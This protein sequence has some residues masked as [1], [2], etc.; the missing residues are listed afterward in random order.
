M[1]FLISAGA[2]LAAAMA[3][4]AVGQTSGA[5]SAPTTTLVKFEIVN[6]TIPSPLTGK[7]GNPKGGERVVVG[8]TDGN[9]LACHAVTA[10]NKE[11]FHGNIGPSL[12][13]VAS[14]LNEGELR[15]RVVDGTKINPDSMMP[16]FYRLEGLNRVRKD[17]V[18]KPVLTA[19]QV[20]DVVAYLM[21]LK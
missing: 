17:V 7:P 2:V 16:S 4:P 8:R 14:R 20:E 3:M 13:G 10:L 6:N 11:E 15:L 12:D 5:A 9:C 18:G 19:E 1:R 21:T